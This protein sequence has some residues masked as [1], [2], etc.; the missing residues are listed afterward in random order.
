MSWAGGSE[1]A[2]LVWEL[3]SKYIPLKHRKKVARRLVSIM[4][5]QDCDNI[6]ECEDLMRDAGLVNE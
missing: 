1:I 4:E 2:I 5:K 6:H 3:M